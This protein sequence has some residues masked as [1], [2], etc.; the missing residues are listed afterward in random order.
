[1]PSSKPLP[2]FEFLV[3]HMFEVTWRRLKRSRSRG[4]SANNLIHVSADDMPCCNLAF[5]HSGGNRRKNMEDLKV[6]RSLP[7]I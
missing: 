7:L 2:S 4:G 3:L 1:M 5:L 6:A